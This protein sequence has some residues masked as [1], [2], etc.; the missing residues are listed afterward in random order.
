MIV[1]IADNCKEVKDYEKWL[2][3]FGFKDRRIVFSKNDVQHCDVVILCG[4]ADLGKDKKRDSLDKAIYDECK[5]TKTR[6][7]GICRGMQLAILKEGGQ[8]VDLE[9]SLVNDHKVANGKS[10]FHEIELSD[11]RKY[12]VNSRHH[13]RAFTLPFLYHTI[14]FSKDGVPEY[15]EEDNILL[16]QCHPEKEEMWETEFQEVVLD[17][18]RKS[19]KN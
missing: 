5:K 1:G 3:H 10:M 4:G 12:N 7:L 15:A 13:Q 2:D 19:E 16:V 11:G 8:V 9:D 18:L 14:G 6:L 17:F